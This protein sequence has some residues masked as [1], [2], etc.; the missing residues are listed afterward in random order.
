MDILFNIKLRTISFLAAF[1][2]VPIILS[3]E[4]ISSYN[5][6]GVTDVAGMETRMATLE[7]ALEEISKQKAD[8]PDSTKGFTSKV[9]G[10]IYFDSYRV[11]GDARLDYNGIKDLRIG[12]TGEGYRNYAY[13][14]DFYFG[15]TNTVEIRDVWLSA[16]SVPLFDTVKIGHHR[17][18]EGI[19]S[20]AAGMHTLFTFFESAD[21][22]T[23]YRLGISSRHLWAQDRIRFFAGVF[24]YKPLAQS[25]RNETTEH[26]NLGTIA[27]TRLTYIP[28]ISRDKNSKIDGKKF[29]L[30]G[31]NYSY[32]D[33]DKTPLTFT[34][35]Y[36][37]LFG[38]LQRVAIGSGNHYH[39]LGFEFAAQQGA[40]ALQSETYLRQYSQNNRKSLNIWGTY[41][42]GRVFLTGDFRKFNTSQ[43]IWTN[44]ALKHNLEFETQNGWNLANYL[45]AW[46]LKGKWSYTDLTDFAQAGLSGVLAERVHD[47][48]FGVN[49]YWTE[50]TRIMF[51]YSRIFLSNKT[52]KHSEIDLFAT[53]FRYHF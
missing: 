37:Q 26:A 9:D 16:S 38:T 28:Y 49:W 40:F 14:V 19:A 23:G 45:G 17:V 21:F 52:G 8:K 43:A 24:E 7:S 51:D 33:V 5:V 31:T 46:E 53:S 29:M 47:F 15:N 30:F 3:A 12:A 27:N 4:D 18:E 13:K 44:V 2:C 10:R 6:V 48:T 11:S 32:Y 41:L 39:Q 1:I 34:E 42:E 25:Q 36:S 35:R 50:R 20:L 22:G